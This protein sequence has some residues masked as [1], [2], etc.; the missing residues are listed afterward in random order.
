M[1]GVTLRG[2]IRLKSGITDPAAVEFFK[3]FTTPNQ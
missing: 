3:H 2:A 1:T